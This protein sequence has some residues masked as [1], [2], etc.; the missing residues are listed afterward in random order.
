MTI[1]HNLVFNGNFQNVI[2]HAEKI[3]P[4]AIKGSPLVYV[5]LVQVL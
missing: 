2:L 4:V 5:I 1:L 3:T